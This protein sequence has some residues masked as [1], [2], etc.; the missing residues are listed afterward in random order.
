MGVICLAFV[1]TCIG[2]FIAARKRRLA[3]PTT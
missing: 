1:I 3:Q 2:S